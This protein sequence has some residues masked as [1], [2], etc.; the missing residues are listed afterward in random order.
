MVS[1]RKVTGKASTIPVGIMLGLGVSMLITVAG[2]AAAAWLI[3]SEVTAQD[4]IGYL[5]AAVLVLSSAAGALAAAGKIKRM[6]LQMCIAFG[7]CYYLT[8]LAMT[9]LFFGGQYEGMGVTAVAV[10]L[11]CAG[12][13]LAGMKAGSRRSGGVKYRR[14]R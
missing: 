3:S 8:L 6:R 10:A 7:V 5:S 2:A 12:G 1:N 13:A 11:G 9:A 14:S 4:S